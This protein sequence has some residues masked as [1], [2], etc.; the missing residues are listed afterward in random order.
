[1]KLIDGCKNLFC[2]SL[3]SQLTLHLFYFVPS[4]SSTY[5]CFIHNMRI[6]NK[7]YNSNNN[8]CRVDNTLENY[9][10][11][12]DASTRTRGLVTSNL[13][14]QIQDSKPTLIKII[15]KSIQNCCNFHI[16]LIPSEKIPI[17]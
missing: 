16:L 15:R 6:G 13:V 14:R 7:Q 4:S 2:C 1:M 17:L 11:G 3:I 10:V 5:C 12:L 9:L 8:N